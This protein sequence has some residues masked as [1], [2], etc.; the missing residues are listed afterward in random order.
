MRI[1]RISFS[2]SFILKLHFR[3]WQKSLMI[4]SDGNPVQWRGEKK[5]TFEYFAFINL[6]TIQLSCH[7]NSKLSLILKHVLIFIKRN[8][9]YIINFLFS[10]N[11]SCSIT[12]VFGEFIRWLPH[13]QEEQQ[14]QEKPDPPTTG[15]R[16]AGIHRQKPQGDLI[17][18]RRPWHRFVNRCCIFL[19]MIVG[20]LGWLNIKEQLKLS[21]DSTSSC[22]VLHST[23]KESEHLFQL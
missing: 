13:W 21:K 11:C 10:N 8:W 6:P 12:E 14:A 23:Q 2:F 17:G 19:I 4:S 18:R 15:L 9:W 7:Q 1:V 5:T 22:I 3:V 20:R 16:G